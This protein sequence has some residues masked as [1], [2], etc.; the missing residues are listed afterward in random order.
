M[1]SF[2]LDPSG[3]GIVKPACNELDLLVLVT[4][5]L[6]AARIRLSNDEMGGNMILP[7]PPP[8]LF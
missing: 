7:P 6:C 3:T 5:V 4:L 1:G 8:P 2:K